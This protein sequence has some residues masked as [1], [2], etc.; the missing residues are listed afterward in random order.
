MT[1]GTS[2]RMRGKR[3]PCMCMR[4]RMRNIPAYA[5]KTRSCAIPWRNSK[6][7]PRVCGENCPKLL[8]ACGTIG[9]SPRM[10]GKRP[11][12]GAR[13]Q[14]EGNIPAYAGKTHWAA[15]RVWWSTEHP[16]VCGENDVTPAE[17]LLNCGTSPRMR[18]K[19][20]NSCFSCL[21]TR[22]I[23]AYAG[24]TASA[25]L[26]TDFPKEHPRVCGE[27][28]ILR[29]LLARLRGTSPRMRGKPMQKTEQAQA[30]GNIPAYAG[31]TA[32]NFIA[33]CQTAEHPRVCGENTEFHF[34]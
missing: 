11:C 20:R 14:G 31:K 16:R 10:R 6:E 34:A 22:N 12:E 29:A 9:T 32:C 7:H 15:T 24:K 19:L 1:N 4:L 23:P 33:H 25:T 21:S 17:Q 18:G 30:K 27:N 8:A 2:P 26:P 13:S 5:G 28:A 3:A